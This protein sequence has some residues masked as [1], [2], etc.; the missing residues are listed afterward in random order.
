MYDQEVDEIINSA[1]RKTTEIE[2]L[3]ENFDI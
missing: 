1:L 2:S 3:I